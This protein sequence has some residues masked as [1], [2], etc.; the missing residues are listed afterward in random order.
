[1][2]IILTIFYGYLKQP[3]EILMNLNEIWKEIESFSLLGKYTWDTWAKKVFA[4]I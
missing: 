3:L 2:A 4:Q 1:M